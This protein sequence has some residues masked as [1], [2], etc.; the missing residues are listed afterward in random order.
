M[1]KRIIFIHGRDIK[2]PKKELRALWFDAVRSGLLRDYGQ[3]AVDL[4]NSISSNEDFV[5][6]GKLSNKFLNEAKGV[7]IPDEIGTRRDA[8]EELKEYKKQ[9]FNET[10]YDSLPGKDAVKELLADS[11]S[12]L[13]S[14][15]GVG[16]FLIARVAPDIEH[17]W[18][19]WSE[20][21]SRVR[22][23]LTTVL[24]SAFNAGDE[25]MLVSHSLGTMISYD[26]LWKFTHYGEYRDDYAGKKV[27]LWVTLGSPLG[28]ENVKRHLKGSTNKGH[29]KYPGNIRKWVNISA[30]D[31][32]VSHDNDVRDDY[33]EMVDLGLLEEPIED[34]YP[35]Y[36]LTVRKNQSNPHSS[37]GYL[38]H[39]EFTKLLFEWMSK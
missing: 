30:E 33:H 23:K 5:Y 20:F 14:F 11:F 15:F 38:I 7:S 26:N 3:S 6:Y 10:I 27:D 34:I 32:Y 19:P 4:F 9:D 35:I 29:I 2:P 39:P 24:R 17:Y 36:N 22:Y 25:I 37:I 18:N 16:S 31:D 28:D 8:L 1:A 21:G 13:L 12:G